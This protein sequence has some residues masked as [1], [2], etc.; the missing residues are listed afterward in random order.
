[1]SSLRDNKITIRVHKQTD[2]HMR[3]EDNSGLRLR[4][5]TWYFSVDEHLVD[6]PDQFATMVS[7]YRFLFNLEQK[8]IPYDKN[9]HMLYT[10]KQR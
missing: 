8:C 9:F 7:L 10:Y 2:E 4:K 6:I 3:M 5:G 1:M